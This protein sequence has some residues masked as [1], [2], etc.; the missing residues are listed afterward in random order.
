M[1][2]HCSVV[3]RG[4]N[5][6][7][8]MENAIQNLNLNSRLKCGL[9]KGRSAAPRSRRNGAGRWRR[10]RGCRRRVPSAVQQVLGG[11]RE[12]G[13]RRG[14]DEM[15]PRVLCARLTHASTTPES[16]Q[17]CFFAEGSDKRCLAHPARCR[18]RLRAR[19]RGGP[20]RGTLPCVRDSP[21]HF[22]VR[23]LA[24]SSFNYIALHFVVGQIAAL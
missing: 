19:D 3:T 6:I 11:A 13:R 12:Y 4:Q 23:S 7:R 5:S 18:H 2:L 10:R 14:G 21:Q 1:R 22:W 8:Q 24:D 16:C 17:Q 9:R 15:Q 20:G